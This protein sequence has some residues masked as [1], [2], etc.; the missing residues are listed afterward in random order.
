MPLTV[1]LDLK[2]SN[3]QIKT[4]V[5]RDGINNISLLKAGQASWVTNLWY[6]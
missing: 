4:E 2:F 6:T 3:N 1:M 5:L